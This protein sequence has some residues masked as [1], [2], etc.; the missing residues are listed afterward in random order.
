MPPARKTNRSGSERHNKKKAKH[1]G[2]QVITD[3]INVSNGQ[4]SST[5]SALLS[6]NQDL[7]KKIDEQG[8]EIKELKG[9]VIFL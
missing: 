3:V 9:F 1:Q 7:I 8:Q 2:P 4:R 6:A 5:P